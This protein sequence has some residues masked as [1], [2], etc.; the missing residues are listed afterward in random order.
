MTKTRIKWTKE[1]A[2]I[3]SIKYNTRTEFQ[4]KSNNAYSAA[5]RN[6]WLDEICG[7]MVL[8]RNDNWSFDD[9]KEIA[10]KY[11]LFS[12]FRKNENAVY[13][14]AQRRGYIDEL[15]SHMDRTNIRWD[16]NKLHQE[17]LKMN[18]TTK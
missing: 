5:L 10:N 2:N 17:V 13:L 15:I 9:M 11:D 18:I 1:L 4:K 3:E 7:H 16:K 14:Y 8:L 6:K 12:D